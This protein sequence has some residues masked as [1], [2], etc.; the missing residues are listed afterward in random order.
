MK[1]LHLCNKVPYPAQDGSSIAMRSMVEALRQP[2]VSLTVWA[3]NTKKHRVSAKKIKQALPSGINF[4]SFEVD[5]SIYWLGMLSNL[6]EGSAYHVSRFYQRSLAQALEHELRNEHYDRIILEGLNMTVYIPLLR[7]WSKAPLVYRAHNIEYEIWE[8]HLSSE[9]KPLRKRYLKEQVKRLKRY[10]QRVWQEV[11]EILFITEEDQSE[12]LRI[13]PQLPSSLVLPCGIQLEDYPEPSANE[14]AVELSYVAAFDWPPN[15]SG[16]EWF[17]EMVWPLIRKERPDCRFLLGGRR[18]PEHFY[19]WSG[20]G[21]DCHEDVADVGTF[22]ARGQV[23][24][25]PLLAGSGMRIKVLENL[26]WGRPMVSTSLGA[27]G[28]S[29]KHRQEIMIANDAETFAESI[30][31]LLKEPKLRKELAAAAQHKVATVYENKQLG[32]KLLAFFKS[33]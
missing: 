26:A 5:T 33:S 22:L 6:I 30:L 27:E 7:K 25:I 13:T 15:Q 8:G 1:I 12:A 20:R 16:M 24:P 31:L 32:R 28:F 29:L 14:Q 2:D 3:L 23:T 21:I 11:D 18:I 9:R 19:K 10:E 17:V 4:R